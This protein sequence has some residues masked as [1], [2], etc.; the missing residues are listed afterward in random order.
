MILTTNFVEL[1][2]LEVREVVGVSVVEVNLYA[3]GKEERKEILIVQVFY[4][5]DIGGLFT[6]RW[7]MVLRKLSMAD[8][9]CLDY[10]MRARE[11]YWP[12]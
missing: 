4:L 10:G 1:E 8:Y 2:D 6:V 12:C 5:W 9:G 7:E 11:L 3:V